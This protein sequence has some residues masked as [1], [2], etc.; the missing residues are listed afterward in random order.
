VT[1]GHI[2][3]RQYDRRWTYGIIGDKK[4]AIARFKALSEGEK[5]NCQLIYGHQAVKLLD[6]IEQPLILSMF[7]DPV[8]RVLS[9]YHYCRRKTHHPLHFLTRSW[10]LE[11][12]FKLG[13]DRRWPEFVDGQFFSIACIMESKALGGFAE[14][15]S[16]ER[17]KDILKKQ[18]VF[19]LAEHFD[20]S[21]LLIKEVLGWKKPVYYTRMNINP[22]P[23]KKPYPKWLVELI[24]DRNK[25]DV[26]LYEFA[27][28]EFARRVGSM[29]TGFS[30]QLKRFRRRNRTLGSLYSH[31]DWFTRRLTVVRGQ[32]G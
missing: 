2:V 13:V 9:L 21:L 14:S 3:A 25:K 20:E 11:E 28:K 16:V 26:E 17:L 23:R 32:S 29:G 6:H 12:F 30:S 22:V 10:T 24:R 18:V 31:I 15:R 19:G 4:K 5:R 1:L 7:R 8:Q 27:E